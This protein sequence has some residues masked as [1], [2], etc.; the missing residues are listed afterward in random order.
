MDAGT[1]RALLQG[2]GVSLLLWL[3]AMALALVAGLF[4]AL[5]RISPR[6]WIRW[7]ATFYVEVVRGIPLLV[8]IV[9]FHFVLFTGVLSLEHRV[10]AILALAVCYAAFMG[11]TYRAGIEAVDPGQM[12]AARALGLRRKD[13]MR[14]VVLPQAVRNVLPALGNE[15]IALLKDTSLASAI[16]VPEL[17]KRAMETAGREFNYLPVLSA[18][19]LVYLVLT[20]LLTRVQRF[21]EG[22]SGG[23]ATDPRPAHH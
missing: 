17:F 12:E 14:F 11:E 19:A 4:V 6:A 13:A 18:V 21:L 16:A 22:R 10:S 23:G 7:P 1:V 2:V 3:G 9:W 15:S 20:F 5:G 8:L